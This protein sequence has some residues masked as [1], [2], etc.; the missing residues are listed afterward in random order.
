VTARILSIELRRGPLWALAIAALPVLA[1]LLVLTVNGAPSWR[2]LSQATLAS[3]LQA[4]GVLVLA[5]AVWQG[6]RERRRGTRELLASTPRPAGQATVAAWLPTVA[7][8]AAAYTL[9]AVALTAL[10]AATFGPARPALVGLFA[11]AELELAACAAVGFGLGRLIPGRFV[12]PLAGAAGFAG[13]VLIGNARGGNAMYLMVLA[14]FQV[15]FWMQP[16]WWFAIAA[17]VWFGGLAAAVLTATGAR[18]RWLVLAPLAISLL[19]AALIVRTPAWRVNTTALAQN[20]PPHAARR[21]AAAG[22]ETFGFG[23]F[24][25]DLFEL[26]GQCHNPRLHARL[27]GE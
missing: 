4:S 9:V 14:P 24:D 16:V 25:R 19:A 20:C 3:E 13:F 10:A 23:P 2:G 5:V 27:G 17:A 12:A 18:R 11:V 6:G 1:L 22:V 8:P 7:W 15:R 21:L 26:A